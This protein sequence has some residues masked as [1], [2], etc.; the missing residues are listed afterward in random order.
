LSSV[1]LISLIFAEKEG[2]SDE[3]E[4]KKENKEDEGRRK[5]G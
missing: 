1:Y 5:D 4:E 3:E 2:D